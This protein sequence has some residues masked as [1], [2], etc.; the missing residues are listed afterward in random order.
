MSC[1]LYLDNND[2]VVSP[3][4]SSTSKNVLKN[5]ITNSFSLILFYTSGDK[6]EYCPIV[7]KL[8]P[9]LVGK[10]SNCQ[11]GM[12]NISQ[13]PKIHEMSVD[14]TTPIKFVP[15]I[16][17][18]VNGTPF[19]EFGGNYTEEDLKQFANEVSKLAFKAREGG[20]PEADKISE[21]SVGKPNSKK[22]CYL[23]YEDAY[24]GNVK[25][26]R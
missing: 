6:C 14:T 12:I 3:G 15:L 8:F 16:I 18:Y 2:F 22:V 19:K 9:R 13:Y 23:N 20:L 10:I 24:T 1:I 4:P 25:Q 26:E 11:I 7:K 5:I 17:F 21:H